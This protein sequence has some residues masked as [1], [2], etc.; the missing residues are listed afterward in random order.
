M[1]AR[2]R[3]NAGT[4]QKQAHGIALPREIGHNKPETAKRSIPGDASKAESVTA[5]P[6][7]IAIPEEIEWGIEASPVGAARVIQAPLAGAEG[8]AEAAPAAAARAVRPAWVGRV[9]VARGAAVGAV[10]DDFKET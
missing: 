6:V 3:D 1:L 2:T 8:S 4:G 7:A 9:A 5:A 10:D